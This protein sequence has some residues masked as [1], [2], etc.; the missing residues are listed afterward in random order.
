MLRQR[1][2]HTSLL[3]HATVQGRNFDRRFHRRR[4]KNGRDR[5]ENLPGH[6][7][8]FGKRPG[9]CDHGRPQPDVSEKRPCLSEAADQ[10]HADARDLDRAVVFSGEGEIRFRSREVGGDFGLAAKDRERDAESE[11]QEEVNHGIHRGRVRDEA[12]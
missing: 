5:S 6:E 9:T 11:R 3:V 4:V 7:V 2:T 10:M 8:I 1:P 12:G